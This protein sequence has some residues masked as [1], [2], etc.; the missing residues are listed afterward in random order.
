MK[1]LL[2]S[3]SLGIHNPVNPSDARI[4]SG[5][6]GPQISKGRSELKEKLDRLIR[7]LEEL[8]AENWTGESF[9]AGDFSPD[10]LSKALKNLRDARNGV[11]GDSH[12]GDSDRALVLNDVGTG[13]R[14]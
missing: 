11:R 3:R 1:P 12:V 6:I 8:I 4:S 5:L 9:G 10:L 13:C 2:S 7:G 14:H